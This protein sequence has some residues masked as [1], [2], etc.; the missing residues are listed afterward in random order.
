MFARASSFVVFVVFTLPLLA[1]A[2]AIPEPVNQARASTLEPRQT[3]GQCSTGTLSCCSSVQSTQSNPL[4]GLLLGLLGIVLGPINAEVGINCSPISV[5][6][7]GGNSCTAQPACCQDNN[8]NGLIT[9][10]CS[11]ISIAL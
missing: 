7:V 2:S 10:G 9:V 1:A 5:I 4:L 6:G 8:F 11:P 3:N